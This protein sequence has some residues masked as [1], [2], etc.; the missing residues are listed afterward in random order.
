[1]VDGLPVRDALMRGVAARGGYQCLCDPP[2]VPRELGA[3]SL[4]GSE[5]RHKQKC[6]HLT[7]RVAGPGT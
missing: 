6:A 5:R 3:Q 2:P 4:V 7:H 1:M